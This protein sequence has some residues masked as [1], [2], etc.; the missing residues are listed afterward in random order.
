MQPVSPCFCLRSH[1]L[2]SLV[3]SR[4]QIQIWST[5]QIYDH[6]PWHLGKSFFFVELLH[7]KQELSTYITDTWFPVLSASISSSQARPAPWERLWG[8][9]QVEPAPTTWLV[10]WINQQDHFQDWIS[11]R[12]SG[13]ISEGM[14]CEQRR[15]DINRLWGV[16]MREEHSRPREHGAQ[17]LQDRRQFNAGHWMVPT[18]KA[19]FYTVESTDWRVFIISTLQVVVKIFSYPFS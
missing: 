6:P 9:Q 1:V 19:V 8:T 16:G 18:G 15:K 11:I 13:Q 17:R 5:L 12:Q 3:L 10:I 14:S 4:A 2:S 7:Q